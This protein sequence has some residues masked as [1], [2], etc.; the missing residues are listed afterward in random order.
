MSSILAGFFF[1]N[2]NLCK[3]QVFLCC[4]FRSKYLSQKKVRSL[5]FAE[6]EYSFGK[7]GLEK[8]WGRIIVDYN[9]GSS[10]FSVCSLQCRYILS[11]DMLV[12]PTAQNHSY[13]H[14]VPTAAPFPISSQL[15]TLLITCHGI[16]PTSLNAKGP[17]LLFST[18]A[19]S[20]YITK[21]F[22]SWSPLILAIKRYLEIVCNQ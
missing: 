20:V 6:A 15:Q 17:S 8:N 5:Q 13:I 7:T 11:P 21:L 2:W 14:T 1:K 12:E 3:R 9:A 4:V 16:G 10:L 18:S 19:C 22:I